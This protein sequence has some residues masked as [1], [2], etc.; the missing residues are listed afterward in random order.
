M[1]NKSFSNVK[2]FLKNAET[3]AAFAGK[4]FKGG[5]TPYPLANFSD[6]NASIG[7]YEIISPIL[8]GNAFF[9]TAGPEDNQVDNDGDFDFTDEFSGYTPAV[10]D[11]LLFNNGVDGEANLQVLGKI[12]NINNASIV[13]L[14]KVPTA[15]TTSDT[16]PG[17]NA[18]KSVYLFPASVAGNAFKPEDNFYLV[19]GTVD[20]TTSSG[21]HDAIPNINSS[22]TSPTGTFAYGV[23]N[24]LNPEYFKTIQISQNAVMDSGL[25]TELIGEQENISATISPVSTYAGGSTLTGP[26]NVSQ[27]PYWAVYEVNPYGVTSSV[28]NKQTFYKV[29]IEESIPAK[30]IEVIGIL[31][32]E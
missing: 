11:Y 29:Q 27:I 2:F 24:T 22:A 15:A 13:T 3:T 30:Q 6:L 23:K 32:T 1:P 19:L 18:Y 21:Y 9:G 5:T 28:F 10:G 12:A 17:G 8:L 31:P 4:T 16:T 26:T 7:Q 25:T 20:Y 14:D